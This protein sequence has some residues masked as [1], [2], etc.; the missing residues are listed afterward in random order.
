MGWV[1]PTLISNV[2]LR[3][4]KGMPGSSNLPKRNKWKKIH[5]F[6]NDS[7]LEAIHSD[8]VKLKSIHI[9]RASNCLI[10]V[11]NQ[12]GAQRALPEAVQAAKRIDGEGEVANGGNLRIL[13][14]P[15]SDRSLPNHGAFH[16]QISCQ[17]YEKGHPMKVSI[18]RACPSNSTEGCS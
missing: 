4:E 11:G 6:R 14:R 5:R 7:R 3:P 1:I 13:P 8:C 18:S 15:G 12:L 2:L 9:R 10:F 17:L 16:H